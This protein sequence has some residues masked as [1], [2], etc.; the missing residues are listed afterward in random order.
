MK[1]LSRGLLSNV[2]WTAAFFVPLILTTLAYA[3]VTVQFSEAVQKAVDPQTQQQIQDLV[4]AGL[5]KQAKDNAG[6]KDLL[7]SNQTIK[8]ICNDEQKAKDEKIDFESGLLPEFGKTKGDFDEKGKP[9]SGGTTY[10]TINCDYLKQFSWHTLIDVL[11]TKQSMWDVLVHELLHATNADRRHPPD[12]TEIYDRWVRNFNAGITDEL[13][14]AQTKQQEKKIGALPKTPT[15]MFAFVDNRPGVLA[16][17]AIGQN[18]REAANAIGLESYQVVATGPTGTIIRAPGDPETVN[19]LAQQR[20]ITLC[21]PAESDVCMIMTPLTAFRGHN[22]EAHIQSN[23]AIHDHE[24]PDPPWEWGVTPPET[25][26]RFS[27]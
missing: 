25:V 22:H 13:K 6:A 17:I 10:I 3:D 2:V 4:N 9:K 16:C 20:R 8:I 15:E 12:D 23:R 24:A 18:P 19:R 5:K 1:H 14:T 7:D 26:V 11:G 27:P 21:F